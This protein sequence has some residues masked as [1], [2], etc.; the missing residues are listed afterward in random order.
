MPMDDY[1]LVGNNFWLMC[2]N[3]ACGSPLMP[4]NVVSGK[5]C[6]ITLQAV[7]GRVVYV[8][9]W[10]ADVVCADCNASRH[11]VSSEYKPDS[12]PVA[13]PVQS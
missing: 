3:P 8:V 12:D 7:M 5:T 13:P 2:G 10:E 9:A 1:K 6:L 4:V 11:F